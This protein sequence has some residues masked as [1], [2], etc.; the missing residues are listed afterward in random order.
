MGLGLSL[1]TKEGEAKTGG[2]GRSEEQGAKVEGEHRSCEDAISAYGGRCNILCGYLRAACVPCSIHLRS[3]AE[4]LLTLFHQAISGGTPLETESA[5]R[6]LATSIVL[7]SFFLHM[8][9]P[10]FSFLVSPAISSDLPMALTVR[11]IAAPC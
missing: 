10:R 4:R 11:N 5:R 8:C 2:R 3:V 6:T 7:R 9:H 1:R